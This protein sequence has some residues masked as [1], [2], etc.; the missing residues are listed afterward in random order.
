[1][2][3]KSYLLPLLS[4]YSH[5]SLSLF[6]DTDTIIRTILKLNPNK[7]PGPDGLTSGFFKSAWAILGPE[8]I[9]SIQRF[10]T[11]TFLPTSI[12]STILTMVPKHPG[13][14]VVSDYI[15]ISCCSTLYKT[16]SKILVSKLKPL[17]PDL[18]LPNQTT[19]VQGRLL[20]ENT[21]LATELV[22]GYHKLLGPK[23][24]V[25]KVDIAKAFDTISWSFVL[26]CLAGIGAPNDYIRWVEDCITTPSF[27][28]GYNGRVHGYF[29][30]KRGLRQGDPLSPYLFVIA[31]NC[32]S[33]ML[34]HGAEEGR[35]NYHEKC[36]RTKLTHLCFA[37]DV[38]IFTDGS[39]SSVLGVL[40]ILEDF[41]SKSGLAVS[42][43]KT[44]FYSCGLSTQEVNTITFVTGLTHGTLP[45]RYLGV[46]LCS[47][48][49]SLLNCESLLPQVKAKVNTWSARCLSFVGR[50][51]LVNTVISGITNFW[52]ATFVLPKACIKKINAICGAYLWNGSTEGAH[53]ARVS[54]ETI[55]LDKREGGLNCRDLV[56]WNCA[57]ILKRI[58]IL[59]CNSG[60]L[61]VAWYKKEVLNGSLRNFWIRKPN[62]K[63]S[64][65]ANKLLKLRGVVY[66]WIKVKVGNGENTRFW[67]DHWT[68]FG[69]LE[70]FL[71]P[72]VARRMGVPANA[73]LREIYLDGNWIIRSPRTDNQ[74]QVQAYLSNLKMTEEED[75]DEWTVDGTH[76]QKYNTGLIYGT[77]KNHAPLVP[78]FQTIWCKGGIPKHNFLAWLFVLNR[79]PTRDRLLGWGLTVDPICL[80]CNSLPESRDHMFFECSYSWEVWSRTTV[81]CQV[82]TPRDWMGIVSYLNSARLPKSQKK[83]LLIAWQCAIYLLW[84]ECNSRLHRSC[85]RSPEAILSSLNLIVRNCCS[86]LRSQNP[87]SSSAMIQMWMQ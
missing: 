87:I 50:L 57:C 10:F 12:N 26:N 53:S 64:W 24:I 29:K 41:K 86:S 9:C 43:Q 14:T 63:Y 33:T 37:Y 40:Q 42:I 18:I 85:F 39:E 79:C 71:S 17:L 61:W 25:I 31:M 58:W 69:C 55:T 6:P 34:N 67:T 83:L 16:I 30:G 2:V 22:N 44:A 36:A 49:L 27:T 60:S 82:S 4:R 47:K 65:L 7:Y 15:P 52:C 74:L 66:N 80:L 72:S 11:T 68:P 13:A 5:F 59:F 51:L 46:P 3:P 62:Q 32:L 84:S 19:F 23:K 35:F 56:A 8:V 78:W 21:V 38:L 20:V 54:W 48:K 81:K 28:V 76:L 73:T 1:M 70:E 45:I 75:T 77:L